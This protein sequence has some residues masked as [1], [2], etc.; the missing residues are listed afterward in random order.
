MA[1]RILKDSTADNEHR[2]F[3]PDLNGDTAVNVVDKE[4]TSFL[5]GI[6]QSLITLIADFTSGLYQIKLRGA[7]DGTLIG[8][9]G[10]ALNVNIE[11]AQL[12]QTDYLAMSRSAGFSD[13]ELYDKIIIGVVIPDE[14]AILQYELA[15]ICQ[16]QIIVAKAGINSVQLLKQACE[17]YLLQENG[18]KLLQENLDTLRVQGL[19][20]VI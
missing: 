20:P 9:K 17:F 8:N 16:F 1:D 4:A 5:G 2:K 18:D 3:I 19:I 12:S 7:T 6:A 13:G 14:Q 15:D 11:S 10:S